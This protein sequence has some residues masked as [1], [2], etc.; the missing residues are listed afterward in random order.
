[1]NYLTLSL[2]PCLCFFS[3]TLH[4]TVADFC[5]LC[6]DRFRDK[7]FFVNV[8][9]TPNLML[10]VQKIFRS[11]NKHQV[12]EFQSDEDAINQFESLLK[13]LKPHP[14]LL[15]LDDVWR[16][17]EFLIER[18]RIS[19]PGFKVLVTS[20]SVFRS[21]ET[22]FRLKLL[23][24]ENAKT[25]FCHSAFKDGIPDVQND[26]VDK[27]GYQSLHAL[28]QLLSQTPAHLSKFPNP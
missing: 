5:S 22:T 27:V 3:T 4:G 23:N 28:Q 20:R 7:I 19:Q 6:T 16:G 14:S 26:L 13:R 21:F 9:R 18:F 2:P 1:M 10:I 8:A 11:K 12:P 25:L 24:D 17:S 15:V